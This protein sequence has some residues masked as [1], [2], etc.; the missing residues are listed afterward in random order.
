MDRH[1]VAF[2]LAVC[3]AVLMSAGPNLYGEA[4][5]LASY[6]SI[7]AVLKSIPADLMPPGAMTDDQGAALK[8]WAAKHLG[9]APVV[10]DM[11]VETIDGASGGPMVVLGPSPTTVLVNGR[12]ARCRVRA[13]MEKGADGGLPADVRPGS[14]IVVSGQ[15]SKAEPL[16]PGRVVTQSGMKSVTIAGWSDSR[17]MFTVNIEGCQLPK[18]PIPRADPKPAEAPASA[19]APAAP[20]AKAAAPGNAPTFFKAVAPGCRKVVYVVDKSG[21]M[22]DSIDFVKYALKRS[23]GDLAETAEFHVIFF[24]SD[25]LVEMSARRLVSATSANKELAYQ[26]ID[27]IT[28]QGETLPATAIERAFACQPDVIFILTD[29]EFDKAIVDLVK[30]LN[31]GGKVAVNTIGFI[32]KSGEPVLRQIAEANKGKYYFVAETDL[33][34]PTKGRK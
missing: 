11:I 8:E 29:G 30:R 33:A 19:P 17:A 13:V 26:F 16:S 4:A 24:S 32:Y 20:A 5:P 28:P 9:G 34:D 18:V 3:V 10:A 22:T 27:G 1:E 7:A 21:S 6:G 15:L 12:A 14:M 23:I 2:L 31:T 25:P